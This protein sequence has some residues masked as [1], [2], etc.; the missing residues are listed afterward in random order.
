MDWRN[1]V[2]SACIQQGVVRLKVVLYKV[3]CYNICNYKNKMESL[4]MKG[5]DS[6]GKE[7]QGNDRSE[8]IIRK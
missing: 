2:F 1:S 6:V 7:R 5:I 8:I 3:V 4:L